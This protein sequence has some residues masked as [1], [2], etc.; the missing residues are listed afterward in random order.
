MI[1]QALGDDDEYDELPDYVKERNIVVMTPWGGAVAIP[2]PW[3]YN[4]I[5]GIGR[6]MS[7]ALSASQGD[8]PGWTAG[9]A[10]YDLMMT[11]L[12]A[13]SPVQGGSLLQ[14]VAPTVFD[15]LAQ[16]AENKTPFG[17]KLRPELFPGQV[18]PES[19]QYWA[20]ASNFSKAA[21]RLVNEFT[22]GDDVTPGW[23]EK[24]PGL[25]LLLNPHHLDAVFSQVTGA[26]GRQTM[27]VLGLPQ[28]VFGEDDLDWRRVPVARKFT[29]FPS[30][31]QETAVYHDRVAQVLDVKRRLAAYSEGPRMDR[32]KARELRRE[33]TGLL[34]MEGYT[35]DAEKQLKSLRKRMQ[36]A[37][38]RGDAAAAKLMKDRMEAVRKRYNETWLRRVSN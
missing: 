32:E 26:V 14:F 34:R 30:S 31:A 36:L 35:E 21:T 23:A 10:G 3:G 7:E 33:S 27:D 16:I 1:S 4:A 9:D 28:Q 29:A 15:P 8:L 24:T 25:G 37:E 18:K 20:N 13:F 19:E 11:F 6:T 22:G 5:W 12:T 2:A 17:E 38:G